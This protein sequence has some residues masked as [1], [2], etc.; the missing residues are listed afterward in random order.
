LTNSSSKSL[1]NQVSEGLEEAAIYLTKRGR[2]GNPDQ[3]SEKL[4]IMAELKDLRSKLKL[5]QKEFAECFD[6][7]LA[8]VR[9]WEQEDRGIP[10]ASSKL[11]ISMIRANPEAVKHIIKESKILEGRL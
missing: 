4:R 3:K 9:N 1:A 6:L 11:L 8:N 5:S 7:P 2:G 10:D